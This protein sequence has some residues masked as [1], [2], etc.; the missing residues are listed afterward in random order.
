MEHNHR[1]YKEYLINNSKTKNKEEEYG[2][3]MGASIEGSD[4]KLNIV[5]IRF[6]TI[7]QSKQLS[8]I[9]ATNWP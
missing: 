9:R 5:K 2:R 7:Y 3:R 6:R 4:V 8:L 1:L